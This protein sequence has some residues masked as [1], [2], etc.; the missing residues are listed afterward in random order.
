MVYGPEGDYD[1]GPLVEI[2]ILGNLLEQE[3]RS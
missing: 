2:K 1:E 3:E